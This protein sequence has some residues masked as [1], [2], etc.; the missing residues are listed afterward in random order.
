M[1]SKITYPIT[2]IS[3]SHTTD[4]FSSRQGMPRC[5]FPILNYVP[6]KHAVQNVRYPIGYVKA[7]IPKLYLCFQLV[8]ANERL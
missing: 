3:M 1:N 8:N 6:L 2:L 4:T 5:F 7:F